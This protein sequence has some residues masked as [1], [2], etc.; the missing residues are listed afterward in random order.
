AS[1]ALRLVFGSLTK[2]IT[3]AG[4][5][6]NVIRFFLRGQPHIVYRLYELIL[7]ST[8]EVAVAGSPQ[9]SEPMI[10]DPEVCLKAVGFE[11]DEGLLPYPARSFLGYRLLTEYFAFP[12]KFL[13]FD[14]ALPDL[15]SHRNLGNQLEVY[16]FLSRS[17]PELIRTVSAQT[18]QLG[19]TPV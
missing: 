16:L 8:I 12:Q 5:G 10:L 11:K 2:E 7:N 4:M 1:S 14:L 13:F 6:L 3:F 17:V 15:G 18:F 9:E 19:C